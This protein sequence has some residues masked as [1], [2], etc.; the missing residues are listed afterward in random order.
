MFWPND[1]YNFEASESKRELSDGFVESARNSCN[2]DGEMLEPSSQC[3]QGNGPFDM[4]EMLWAGDEIGPSESRRA[5]ANGLVKLDWHSNFPYCEMH[6]PSS[7]QISHD[8]R[9]PYMDIVG[10]LQNSLSYYNSDSEKAPFETPNR[11]EQFDFNS[12]DFVS[13]DQPSLDEKG[14]NLAPFVPPNYSET[15]SFNSFSDVIHKQD[16][17]DFCHLN[18]D[19]D[20]FVMEYSFM[21]ASGNESEKPSSTFSN[22]YRRMQNHIK[23][24]KNNV[25][26]PCSSIVSRA[27]EVVNYAL[28]ASRGTEWSSSK[29]LPSISSKKYGIKSKVEMEEELFESRRVH[30]SPGMA[31]DTNR[32]PV[33]E[34]AEH[35]GVMLPPSV[36]TGSN[37]IKMEKEVPKFYDCDI[38]KV[39]Y[40]GVQSKTSNQSN[41]EDDSDLCILEDMSA[42]ARSNHVTMNEMPGGSKQVLTS[43]DPGTQTV[44]THSRRKPND[45][46][47]IFRVALQV[48]L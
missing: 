10:D 45:E 43:R 7:S 8:D 22:E 3:S 14:T 28:N 21:P 41:A 24:E 31:G 35:P 17:S 37:I 27:S 20:S 11:R 18:H 15:S 1:T 29:C 19:R 38:S 2:P 30:P 36:I 4:S 13:H 26:T 12:A 9:F 44:T 46:R 5:P 48:N 6:E 39:S 42:P 16:T 47:V 34:I 33:L 23:V 25:S 32:E 40:Q